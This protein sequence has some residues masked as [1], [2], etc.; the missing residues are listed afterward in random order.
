MTIEYL[1]YVLF[2]RRSRWFEAAGRK[3]EEAYLIPPR[4]QGRENPQHP[5]SVIASSVQIIHA[6]I[7]SFSDESAESAFQSIV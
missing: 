1:P 3:R 6:T 7:F 5:N 2:C 4:A